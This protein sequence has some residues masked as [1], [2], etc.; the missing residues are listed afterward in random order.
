MTIYGLCPLAG[1]FALELGQ[2]TKDG[3]TEKRSEDAWKPLMRDA[4]QSA[5]ETRA[6]GARTGFF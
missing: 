5:R 2:A 4:P 3:Q 1:Q 6:K